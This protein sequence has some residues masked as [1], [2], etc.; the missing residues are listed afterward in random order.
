MLFTFSGISN[1]A[2]SE[3]SPSWLQASLPVRFGGLGVHRLRLLSTSAFLSSVSR[4]LPL[5]TDLL[6][7][8]LQGL[9]VPFYDEALFIWQRESAGAAP[10]PSAVSHL[11]RAWDSLLVESTLD[12][13][14]DNSD[15]SARARLQALQSKEAGAWL[16]ALPI[17]SIGLRLEPDVFHIAI[18]LRL[19]LS[20]STQLS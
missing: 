6:P 18:G 14:L 5:L 9:S 13:L 19:G 8:R 1:V 12:T 20:Y 7:S 3:S 15:H 17:A 2:I 10:A 4:C 16:N 11:Q